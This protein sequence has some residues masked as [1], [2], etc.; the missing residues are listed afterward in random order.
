MN[1]LLLKQAHISFA[2]L[3]ISGF[4]LRWTWVM[5]RS[6]WS[7][8]RLTKSV[9]HV[10]DTLFLISGLMLAFTLGQYPFHTDWLT[11]KVTG[12]LAYILLGMAAM[13]KRASRTG[14]VVAFLAA[15][16]SYAWIVSVALSKSPWGFLG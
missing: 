14:K 1:F 10:I 12:L 4:V 9:P 6:R 8:H 5:M 16:F 7:H 11:A 13:S 15:V 2:L 3:S